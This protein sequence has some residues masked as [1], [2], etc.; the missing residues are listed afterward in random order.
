VVAD[1]EPLV[2][3]GVPVYNGESHLARALD[4]LLK[5]QYQNVEIIVSDNGS[6]DATPLICQTYA[7]RDPR[8]KIHRSDRNM[9]LAWNFNRVFNLATGTYFMWAAHDDER[10]PRFLAACVSRLEAE[11]D[12]VLCQ[13]HT[14]MYIEG[15]PDLLCVATLDSFEGLRS[16][17][18][19]YRETLKRFPATG[20]YG[21]Y[22]HA[23]VKKTR[24]FQ[25]HIA[26]DVAFVQELSIY[27]KFVQVPEILFTYYG[28]PKWNTVQQDYRAIYGHEKPAYYLPFVV[29]F[30]SHWKR[31]AAASVSPGVKIRLWCALVA[32]QITQLLVK[33]TIKIAGRICPAAWRERLG[34]ALYMRFVHSRN[35]RVKSDALFLERV[36]KPTLGWWSGS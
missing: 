20:F 35:V 1:L 19:R 28:R 22:R 7:T 18:G 11:P 15:R 23:A 9:G 21:L 2:S 33:I 6:V 30:W 26:T 14:A 25:R 34:T 32:H 16:V 10:D 13:S 36:I 27:G 17:T 4:S 31:I 29:L 12:A 8:V 5:Q 3:I 24:I